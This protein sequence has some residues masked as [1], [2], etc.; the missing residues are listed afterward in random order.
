MRA[1]A[2]DAILAIH[3][4]LAIFLALGLVCIYIGGA[5]NWRWT[6]DFWF[7]LAHA[8]AFCIVAAEALLGVTC[9]LTMWEDA[10]RQA[11][12]Q[13]SFIAR[14]M[15]HLLYYDLPGWAFTLVYVACAVMTLIA[16]RIFPPR[17]ATQ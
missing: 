5:L 8:T 4:A 6:R 3:L 2:A 14:W 1:A 11:V 12:G 15:R 13:P 17:R 10:L 7:R 9:P 16:W